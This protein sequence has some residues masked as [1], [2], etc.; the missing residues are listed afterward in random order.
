EGVQQ[1]N[2]HFIVYRQYKLYKRVLLKC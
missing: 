2:Y 1:N